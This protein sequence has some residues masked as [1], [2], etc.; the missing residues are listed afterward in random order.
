MTDIAQLHR[1]LIGRV[2][3]STASA[4]PGLR[5]SAFDNDGLDEPVR[6]LVA[7]VAERSFAV[8]DEDVAAARAAGLSEDQI[9]EVV[10]CAAVGA[11]DRQYV[12]ALAALA[13]ATGGRR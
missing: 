7:K 6:T 13:E 10:V 4:P 5:R 1:E 8:T 3:E 12:A 2:L 9:F 11:A